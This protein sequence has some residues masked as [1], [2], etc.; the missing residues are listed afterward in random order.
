MHNESYY[1]VRQKHLTRLSKLSP[2]ILSS[3]QGTETTAIDGLQPIPRDL[4]EKGVV[5][6]F[7]NTNKTSIYRFVD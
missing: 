1:C 7:V 3:M 6:M 2:E 4:K 5:A